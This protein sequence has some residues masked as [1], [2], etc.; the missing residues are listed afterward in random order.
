[1]L[2]FLKLKKVRNSNQVSVVSIDDSP[3]L[4]ISTPP[5]SV[6]KQPTFDIGRDV[7]EKLLELITSLTL[8]EIYKIDRYA[9]TFVKRDSI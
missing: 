3:F 8:E 6:V 1:M 4:E 2:R 7:A 9:P 5:T